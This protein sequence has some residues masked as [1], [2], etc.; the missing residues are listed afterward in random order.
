[1]VLAVMVIVCGRRGLCPSFEPRFC[2]E[3]EVVITTMTRLSW[4]VSSGAAGIHATSDGFNV[5]DRTDA[6]TT[7]RQEH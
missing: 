3:D 1:M 4:D 2:D 7:H 5:D 6:V